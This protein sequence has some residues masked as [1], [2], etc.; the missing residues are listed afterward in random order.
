MEITDDKV[1]EEKVEDGEET[2]VKEVKTDGKKPGPTI[3]KPVRVNQKIYDE[4]I[5]GIDISTVDETGKLKEEKNHEINRH[6]PKG[7]RRPGIKPK[8]KRK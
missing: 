3:S 8:H 6:L 1:E 4:D 5:G 2:K 7:V